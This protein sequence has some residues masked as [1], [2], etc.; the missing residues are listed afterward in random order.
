MKQYM[1][2]SSALRLAFMARRVEARRGGK[3]DE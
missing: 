2:N 3:N 1:I